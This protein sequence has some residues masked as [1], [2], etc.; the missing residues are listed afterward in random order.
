LG[1]GDLWSVAARIGGMARWVLAGAVVVVV[2]LLAVGSGASDVEMDRAVRR[3]A[4]YGLSWQGSLNL[5]RVDRGTLRPL[6][7]PH[8]R[9]TGDSEVLGWSFARDRSRIVLGSAARGATLRLIDLRAMRELGK[10]RIARRGSL[11]ATAWAGAR[12]VLAVVVTP[13]CCGAGDTIVVGVDSE[14]RRVVWRRRLG[15]SLQSGQRAGGRLLL[16]L[17]PRGRSIGHSRLV[18]VGAGGQVRSAALPHIRSGTEPGSSRTG[19]PPNRSW[20]WDPGLAVDSSGARAFVVQAQAPVAEIE[21]SSF[22]VRSHPL[23]GPAR[24]PNAV[25]GHTRY[26]LWLGRDRLA[27]TGFDERPGGPR[28]AGL[29]LI[30]TRRWRAQTI[31]RHTTEAALVSATLLASSFL[32][33]AGGKIAGSGLTGYTTAGRRRFHLYGREPIVGVEPLG[34]RAL[35]GTQKRTVLIAAHTGRQIRNYRRFYITLLTGDQPIY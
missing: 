29:T 20:S 35:I 7:G 3:S 14:R 26:A 1:L 31:D 18:E 32:P 11:V 19:G 13:G 15:G 27:V 6:A 33:S 4:L 22:Q 8:V 34:R 9:V 28:P 30:D 24:A 21:L 25:V 10:V 23:G 12:R 2:G 5:V 16:V 17:G